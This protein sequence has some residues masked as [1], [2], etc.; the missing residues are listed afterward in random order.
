[1]I[2]TTKQKYMIQ[3]GSG[4]GASPQDKGKPVI[5]YFEEPEDLTNENSHNFTNGNTI[6]EPLDHSDFYMTSEYVKIHAK[7]KNIKYLKGTDEAMFRK[8]TE[9]EKIKWNLNTEQLLTAIL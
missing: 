9:E 8:P 2:D 5:V 6:W 7:G 3:C 1:M 4:G